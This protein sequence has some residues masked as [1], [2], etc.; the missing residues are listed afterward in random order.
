MPYEK[1]RIDIDTIIFD[2]E[3]MDVRMEEIGKKIRKERQKKELSISRLAQLSNLSVSCVSK[4]ESE[5]CRI[6]LKTLLRIAA[7]LEIPVSKFLET[8]EDDAG[9]CSSEE[10]T[11]KE[12]QNRMDGQRF[13]EFT[14]RADQET[15]EFILDMAEEL[16]DMLERDTESGR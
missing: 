6:S 7:A 14:D 9:R 16:V 2:E 11:E 3:K 1:K 4:A 8:G 13:R 15:I 10:R 12:E 5:R